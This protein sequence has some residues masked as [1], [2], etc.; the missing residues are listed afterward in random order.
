MTRA[1]C[2]LVG[3]PGELQGPRAVERRVAHADV[4]H[5]R[6]HADEAVGVGGLKGILAV[7]HC[8][9]GFSIAI[10]RAWRSAGF[11]QRSS[12]RWPLPRTPD[13]RSVVLVGGGTVRVG[14]RVRVWLADRGVERVMGIGRR[15]G[16]DSVVSAGE[17]L[18][19]GLGLQRPVGRLGGIGG[20]LVD[21][22]G[23]VSGAGARS[24]S[25][26]AASAYPLGS[27]TAWRLACADK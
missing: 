17:W 24:W 2:S 3:A 23:L 11:R 4:R 14:V 7:G 10:R 27:R 6:R 13:A 12:A 19:R 1:A 5:R 16:R 9:H 21:A 25:L 22:L 20:T 8:A 18:V 15:A 26:L